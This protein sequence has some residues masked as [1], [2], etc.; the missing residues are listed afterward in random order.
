M[1]LRAVFWLAGTMCGFGRVWP[2]DCDACEGHSITVP[3]GA[4]EAWVSGE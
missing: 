2:A 4:N 3:K 1:C